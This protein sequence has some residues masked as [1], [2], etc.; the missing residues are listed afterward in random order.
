MTATD[1]T[2]DQGQKRDLPAG[3]KRRLFRQLLTELGPLLL[4]FLVFMWKDILWA[5]AFYAAATV[6]AVGVSMALH[7]KLPILPLISAVLVMI[8]AGLTLLL[9]EEMFIKIK[10]TV[11]NGFYGLTLGVG[12]LIGYRLVEKVL[13]PECTLDEDG[14]RALTLRVTAYLIGLALLNELVWRTVSTD[15]WVIFKVF[16]MVGLN[17]VFAWSQVPLVRRHL[18]A[19]PGKTVSA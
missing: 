6:V 12:W 2:A 3:F 10:P 1:A 13:A 4:F 7:R 15:T 19:T 11:I 5:T 14:L 8:F 17:L 16:V 9:E 18:R